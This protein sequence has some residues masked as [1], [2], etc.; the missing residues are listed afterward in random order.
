M[1]ALKLGLIISNDWELYGDGSGDFYENQYKPTEEL[2]KTCEE[3]GAKLTLMAEVGQQWAH[4]KLGE[5]EKWAFEIAAAW[6]NQVKDAVKRRHDVQ[7][8]LHPQ[9][10]KATFID[11]KWVLDSKY[12]V[13]SGLSQSEQEEILKAGKEYLE[14]LLRPVDSEYSCIGFRAGG[15]CIKPYKNVVQS[16]LNVG[17]LSDTSVTK[18]LFEYNHYDY[19]DAHS[20]YKP[21]FTSPSNIKL[22]GKKNTGLLEI[23]IYSVSIIDSPLLRKTFFPH[24]VYRY[25]F[26][27]PLSKR[28]KNWI[29]SRNKDVLK[30]YSL[31]QRPAIRDNITNVNWIISQIIKKGRL[32]LD[33]VSVPA[34]IFVNMLQRLA[35]RIEQNRKN[36]KEFIFPVMAFGHVKSMTTCDNINLI[37]EKIKA[38][39]GE[40]VIFWTYSDA[41]RYWIDYFK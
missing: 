10:F 15:A 4:P 7:L 38:Q 41:I 22:Q 11:G 19:R 27:S 1:T 35:E 21:W 33:Y 2:L 40:N 39:F 17:I 23:P 5:T 8:H 28:E 34:S 36:D 18:G 9:W 37:F 32:Q 3:H 13:F 24:V 14:N 6:E 16:L 31:L 26:R 12:S 29:K 30:R 20:H 25:N